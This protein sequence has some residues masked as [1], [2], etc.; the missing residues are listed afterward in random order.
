MFKKLFP[1]L[2][3]SHSFLLVAHYS[4]DGDAI[5]STLAMGAALRKMG[6]KVYLY[7]RDPVPF[8]LSFLPG[9]KVIRRTLP[10]EKVDCAIMLDCAQPKRIS[11]EFH[12]A[13]E[14][15]K[16]SKVVCI[17]HHLLDHAV[18]DVDVID[19]K[20]AATGVIVWKLIRALK[21]RPNADMANQIFCAVVVDTGFFRYSSTTASVLQLGAELVET[22]ASPWL[23]AQNLEE[24]EP[25]Q[26]YHLMQMALGTLEV[27]HNGKIA[28][29]W[30]T[31]KML[32]KT[33]A[34]E[35]MCEEFSNIPRSIHG[36]EAAIFLRERDDGKIKVSLRSKNK[37]SVAE[38][39]K[40]F[41]GGGH[42]HAA[43]CLFSEPIAVVKKKL[44][45]EIGKRLR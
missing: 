3:K 18:G 22:G 28:S 1:I 34:T 23:V 25:K 15:G 36:V 24:S 43:G 13:F 39:S 2:K 8:N 31:Q 19:P 30:V 26:R 12:A 16:F 32:K 9:A 6:K 33:H 5:G 17:D 11:K 29:M 40:K 14:S 42:K 4:P 27:T 44:E 45:K 35:E 41:D 7:N 37:I 21:I 20:A 10:K 38:I